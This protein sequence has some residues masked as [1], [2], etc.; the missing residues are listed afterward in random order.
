M[1]LRHGIVRKIDGSVAT[2]E[3]RS[4][5]HVQVAATKTT[6]VRG[7][8]WVAWNYYKDEPVEILTP[9][10]L[11]RRQIAEE[12]AEFGVFSDRSDRSE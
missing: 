4:G 7:F 12:E 5:G 10:D 3:L 11:N 1:K 6:K 2:V 8:V 9:T